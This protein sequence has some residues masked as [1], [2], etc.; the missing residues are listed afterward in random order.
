[1]GA[2]SLFFFGWKSSCAIG[3][4]LEVTSLVG[5]GSHWVR[6]VPVLV[7]HQEIFILRSG[8]RTLAVAQTAQ[9]SPPLAVFRSRGDVALRDVGSGHGG[10]G[11][12]WD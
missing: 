11:W 8:W 9:Q 12:G 4:E 10:V 1:M 3:N 7:G 6:N 5:R 2:F